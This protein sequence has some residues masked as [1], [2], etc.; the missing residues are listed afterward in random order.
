MQE[1]YKRNVNGKANMGG[2]TR[3]SCVFPIAFHV[4]SKPSISR[5]LSALVFGFVQARF[6]LDNIG[7]GFK[8]L[9]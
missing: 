6:Q 2:S 3:T 4:S 7:F 9:G 8:K 1:P 5:D